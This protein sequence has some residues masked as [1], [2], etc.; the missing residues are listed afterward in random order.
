MSKRTASLPDKLLTLDVG[1]VLI[2]PDPN[3]NLD[4]AMQALRTKSPRLTSLKFQTNR[5]RYIE[6]DRLL[7]AVKITRIT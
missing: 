5:I 3:K 6:G 2:L 1:E 7:P 4:R